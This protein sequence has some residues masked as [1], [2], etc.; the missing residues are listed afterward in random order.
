[1]IIKSTENSVERKRSLDWK[2]WEG[3]TQG[4]FPEHMF[5]KYL[6]QEGL[7]VGAVEDVELE[8]G[9]WERRS[10]WQEQHKQRYDMRS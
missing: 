3:F 7:C 4:S 1:M 5:T 6:L 10:K 8:L 2:I 9:I